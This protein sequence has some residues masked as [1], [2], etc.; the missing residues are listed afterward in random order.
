[1]NTI[2]I[3]LLG[4][5]ALAVGNLFSA[6]AY[7]QENPSAI[8]RVEEDWELRINTPDPLQ[9]SPQVS[10]WMS[11]VGQLDGF[12]FGFDLNHAQ[13]AGYEGGGFQT[14]AMRGSSLIDEHIGKAGENLRHAGEVVRW[15]QFIAILDSEVVFAIKNGTSSSWGNFGGPDTLVRV[16]Q[17]LDNLNSYNPETS[18]KASGIGFASN[19]VASLRLVRVRLYTQQGLPQQIELNRELQE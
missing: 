7:G 18:C 17:R 9:D 10:T 19:R 15:T 5:I 6:S 8:T 3:A 14:K 13:H 12:H 2:R 4:L 11:P 1:M 16:P